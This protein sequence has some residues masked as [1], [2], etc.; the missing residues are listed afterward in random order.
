MNARENRAAKQDMRVLPGDGSPDAMGVLPPYA[1]HA[2]GS[3]AAETTDNVIGD[4]AVALGCYTNE[5]LES[6]IAY[7][8]EVRPGGW[9]ETA[10]SEFLRDDPDAWRND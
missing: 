1:A 6:V 2:T 4:I 3:R 5:E 9:L 8:R 10:V 7:E